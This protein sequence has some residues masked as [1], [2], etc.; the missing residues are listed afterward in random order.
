M[1]P[2]QKSK[3]NLQYYWLPST[4]FEVGSLFFF[5]FV[6]IL[7]NSGWLALA[8]PGVSEDSPVSVSHFPV[9]AMRSQ[10]HATTSDF[11]QVLRFKLRSSCLHSKCFSHWNISSALEYH[12]KNFTVCSSFDNKGTCFAN[13][14]FLVT[15]WVTYWTSVCKKKT[16][17]HAGWCGFTSVCCEYVSLPSVNE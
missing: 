13:D 9:A 15:S 6:H 1:C 3:D 14:T 7:C 4:S 2:E 10:I 8:G 5:F 17:A 12:P 16:K 11:K